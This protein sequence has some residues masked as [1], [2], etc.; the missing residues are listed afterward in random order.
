MTRDTAEEVVKNLDKNYPGS[1]NVETVEF[2]LATREVLAMLDTYNKD[3]EIEIEKS[4][5][6]VV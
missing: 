2:K 6:S 5:V 4:I 3:H 1:P